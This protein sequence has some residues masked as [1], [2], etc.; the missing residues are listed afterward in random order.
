MH[1]PDGFYPAWRG[2][3]GAASRRRLGA[4]G[5]EVL[6]DGCGGAR[7][8]SHSSSRAARERAARAGR[9]APGRGCCRARGLAGI[10]V[11]ASSSGAA[12]SPGR[13]GAAFGRTSSRWA[14]RRRRGAAV[15]SSWRGRAG[16][17]R[18]RAGPWRAFVGRSSAPLR[19]LALALSG[20]YP[21]RPWSRSC[22]RC[23]CH[24]A[25]GSRAH[26]GHP[27]DDPAL[28]ARPRARLQAAARARP[29]RPR[30]RRAGDR[31]GRP[32]SRPFASPLPDGLESVAERLGFADAARALWPAP[33]PTTRCPGRRS[34]G[35]TAL[36]VRSAGRRRGARVALS[37]G[38][39][40][41]PSR[42][43]R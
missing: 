31:P 27:R 30:P 19:G 39:A 3:V 16:R 15:A 33:A 34:A 40:L 29:G 2:H 14:W 11:M 22:S 41:V 24:R 28:A 38:L 43:H 35:G 17:A 9:A 6:P 12:C 5:G 8:A 25:P 4:A 20:L 1:I 23:T 7:C 32:P 26:R 36:A 42:A 18:P 13:R 37:R 10:V 21:R